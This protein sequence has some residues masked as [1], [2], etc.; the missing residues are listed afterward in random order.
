MKFSTT[1][2]SVLALFNELQPLR[3]SASSSDFNFST[4][5]L[6]VHLAETQ[7]FK[8]VPSLMFFF[9]VSVTYS[10]LLSNLRPNSSESPSMPQYLHKSRTTCD[11]LVDLERKSPAN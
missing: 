11:K 5:S 3:H 9:E 8:I 2:K 6:A 1:T 4:I 10:S 7:S